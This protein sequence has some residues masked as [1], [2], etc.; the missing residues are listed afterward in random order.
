MVS[1]G[2]AWTTG[3]GLRGFVRVTAVLTAAP[4]VGQTTTT[5]TLVG[6]VDIASCS[7]DRDKATAN[8]LAN[9]SGP[10]SPSRTT[11]TPTAPLRSSRTATIPPGE[12]R[13]LAPSLR[14]T[15]TT[16]R[17]RTHPATSGTQAP[18]PETRPNATIPTVGAT[19]VF[20]CSTATALRWAAAANSL[21]KVA[22]SSRPSPTTRPGA[23]WP[24]STTRFSPLP[25]RFDRCKAKRLTLFAS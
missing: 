23:P 18:R 16:T 4:G 14:Q 11:S 17:R 13:R 5:V 22:G 3:A 1:R 12:C 8:V 20:S 9:V 24:T 19:G 15:T 2:A 10:S 6:A 25:G 7:S 21:L